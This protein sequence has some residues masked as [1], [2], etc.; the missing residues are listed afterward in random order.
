MEATKPR[1][2]E[3]WLAVY[4]GVAVVFLALASLF[5]AY[6]LGGAAKSEVWI[7][8][9]DSIHTA[10][11]SFAWAAFPHDMGSE[12]F[13][14]AALDKEHLLMLP[15]SMFAPPSDAAGANTLRIAF[16]NVDRAGID[17]MFSRL[18]NL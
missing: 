15:G 18:K 12:A 11:A 16:A 4:I 7:E 13:A 5:G 3:D 6:L 1:V 10:S 9:T 17:E 14:R 2:N 8:I